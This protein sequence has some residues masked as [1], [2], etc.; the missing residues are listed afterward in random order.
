MCSRKQQAPNDHGGMR[1]SE[2]IENN[3]MQSSRRQ[4]G[5]RKS[6]LTRRANQ[7]LYSN[8]PKCCHCRHPLIAGAAG[9][10]LGTFT[11]NN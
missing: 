5:V 6:D 1:F 8:I 10:R 3:P 4:A 2:N 7:W 11:S 9:L